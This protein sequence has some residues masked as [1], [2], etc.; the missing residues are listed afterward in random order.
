MRINVPYPTFLDL[1]GTPLD[2]GYIYIGSPN[3]NPET[4]PI[5]VYWDAA[6]T[7]TAAQPIRTLAGSFSRIGTPANLYTSANYSI[8]VRNKNQEIV[9][10][11]ADS[12]VFDPLSNLAANLLDSTDFTQGVSLIGGAMRIVSN[13]ATL[14]LLPGSGAKYVYTLGYYTPG[15]GG[16]TGPFFQGSGSENGGSI[17][18]GQDGTIWNL[19]IK[20]YSVKQFGA[21]GDGTTDDRLAIQAA[22]DTGRAVYVPYSPGGYKISSR[23]TANPGTNIRADWGKTSIIMGSDN[24]YFFEIKGGN[25]AIEGFI[26][27][28]SFGNG[29]GVFL[30]R[31]DLGSV[32]QVYIKNIVTNLAGTLVSDISS[33]S[34]VIANVQ[35]KTFLCLSQRG[36]GFSLTQSL[37]ISYCDWEDCT[38]SYGTLSTNANFTAYMLSNLVE[39]WINKC[40]AET[41]G[42]DMSTLSNNNAFVIS[43]SE[44][45]HLTDCVINAC[46]GY[47]YRVTNGSYE[48]FISN[49]ESRSAVKN[50]ILVDAVGSASSDITIANCTALGAVG[51]T[52]APTYD[53]ISVQGANRVQISNCH[54]LNNTG[55]GIF[56]ASATHVTINGGRSDFNVGRGLDSSGTNTA[57]I[58]GMGFD[59]NT[60]GN[61]SL[62]SS[63][64][65]L[66]TC[67][68]A[69]GSLISIN[70]PGTA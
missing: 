68:G 42:H 45:V 40:A 23:L 38:I 64:M 21:K 70:G 36:A 49:C 31:T 55:A 18:V 9:T 27:D 48:V 32:G 56:L 25:I 26:V 47:G 53:G 4:N 3:L 57:L 8:T 16:G 34:N 22:L 5:V 51:N 15:D 69:A 29:S 2:G 12:D 43:N 50:G 14:R 6:L 10:T 19:S 24:D 35:F 63:N 7:Q 17:I 54:A 44:Q 37:R 13:V 52:Y 39:C 66:A 59:N 30:F 58:S 46:G 20:E 61:A 1:D 60:A 11:F 65:Y 33:V 67:Q 28:C 62:S 41:L